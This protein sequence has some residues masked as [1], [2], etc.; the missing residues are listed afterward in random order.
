MIGTVAKKM[1]CNT[2]QCHVASNGIKD[3][4]SKKN[5]RE[6]C[7]QKGRM[8]KKSMMMVD[9]LSIKL[10]LIDGMFLRY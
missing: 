1:R 4:Q 9:I 8:G 6:K 3:E 2:I 5:S 10:H 7:G